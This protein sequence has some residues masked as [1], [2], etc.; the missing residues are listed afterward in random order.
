MP[1]RRKVDG[2]K[3]EAAAIESG[4]KERP[5]DEP[6]GSFL[7]TTLAVFPGIFI[8]GIGHYAAGDENSAWK[9][10]GAEIVSIALGLAGYF[11]PYATDNDGKLAIPCRILTQAGTIGFIGSFL[12]DVLG[13]YRGAEQFYESTAHMEGVRL[14][15]AYR[16][17]KDPLN[18]FRHHLALS[19]N[20][21][22]GRLYLK[23]DFD[24]ETGTYARRINLDLGYALYRGAINPHNAITLGTKLRRVE[25]PSYGLATRGIEGYVG[26]QKDIGDYI[27]SIKGFYFV[28]RIGY[29]LEYYQF[30][31]ETG[32]TPNILDDSDFQDSYLVM[33]SGFELNTGRHTRL[34]ALLIQD[35]TSDVAP[36]SNDI[37][38]IKLGLVHSYSNA[39]DIQFNFTYGDGWVLW[40]GL[41]YG[42]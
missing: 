28:G 3:V 33:E 11:L 35:P 15:L 10:L 6:A 4:Y 27:P 30:G 13:A 32:E 24:L 20:A 8:H 38:L 29:G 2:K 12:V 34:Q 41:D 23:P 31:Q 18:P 40:L 36:I 14:G 9:L 21:F 42:L 39:F 7:G 19:M 25:L 17:T 22:I 5:D 26:F 16:Y 37:G 1:R